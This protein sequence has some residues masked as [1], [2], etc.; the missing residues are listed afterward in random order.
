MP[1]INAEQVITAVYKP[2]YSEGPE[3]LAKNQEEWNRAVWLEFS[4]ALKL[5]KEILE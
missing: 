4:E 3:N 5:T 2:G 1:I